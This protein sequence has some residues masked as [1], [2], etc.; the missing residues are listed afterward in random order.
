MFSY[1]TAP[2]E[3]RGTA[4][5]PLVVDGVVEDTSR[6]LQKDAGGWLLERLP[7]AVGWPG[8]TS[9]AVVAATAAILEMSRP[10]QVDL[11]FG[12]WQNPKWNP[13]ASSHF[14]ARFDAG[15]ARSGY[16]VEPDSAPEDSGAHEAGRSSVTNGLLCLTSSVSSLS[17]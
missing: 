16:G 3:A 1:D 8:C 6:G 5:S 15:P 2:K 12:A 10:A 17:R 9:F 14:V 4:T 11:P 7:F 13:V